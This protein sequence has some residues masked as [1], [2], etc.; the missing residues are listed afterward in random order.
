[1]KRFLMEAYRCV[2]LDD[3]P[4]WQGPALN[5]TLIFNAADRLLLFYC[6]ETRAR[7]TSGTHRGGCSEFLFP[8][9]DRATGTNVIGGSAVT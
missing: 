8:G 3:A 7:H 4:R 5:Q 2:N 1:M 9:N 6:C